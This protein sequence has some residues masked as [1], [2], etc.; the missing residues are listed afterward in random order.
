[1]R[2]DL[3]LLRLSAR[4]IPLRGWSGTKSVDASVYKTCRNVRTLWRTG[5]NGSRCWLLLRFYCFHIFCE[6]NLHSPIYSYSIL[7]I[8]WPRGRIQQWPCV[9]I[10]LWADRV[11]QTSWGVTA[12]WTR[13][14]RWFPPKSPVGQCYEHPPWEEVSGSTWSSNS[15]CPKSALNKPSKHNQ[16]NKNTQP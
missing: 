3:C 6:N 16:T 8:F 7:L 2:H 5:P 13:G 11:I 14:E 12:E 10:P 4:Q 9:F 1:M 15:E